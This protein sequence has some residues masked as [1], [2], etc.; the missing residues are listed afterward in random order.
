MHSTLRAHF[1]FK[2]L[3]LMMFRV[4][5]FPFPVVDR[6]VDWKKKRR[7]H[8]TINTEF[9]LQGVTHGFS[10]QFTDPDRG[11]AY[12]YC[13]RRYVPDVHAHKMRNAFVKDA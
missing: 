4:A 8:Q 7:S 9:L 11:G 3:L 1:T 12:Y 2:R 5:M 13:V 10:Y 6:A